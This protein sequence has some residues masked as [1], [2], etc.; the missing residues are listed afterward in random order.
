VVR[1]SGC[2][3]VRFLAGAPRSA[4][5]S[6]SGWSAKLKLVHRSTRDAVAMR[7]SPPSSRRTV[8]HRIIRYGSVSAVSTATSL[9]I[10]GVLVGV[11]GYSAVWSNVVATAIGTIPSFELNR[12]WVWS[13]RNP[14]SL[15]RQ[16]LPYCTL[17]FV[18]LIV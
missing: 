5:R 17:S 6:L 10:L 2:T 1:W 12:R 14:R 11:C 8:V 3:V 7:L 9:S 18:G 16:A 15:L 13:Q 4:G